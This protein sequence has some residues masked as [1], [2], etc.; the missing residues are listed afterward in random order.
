MAITFTQI[1]LIDE[2]PRKAMLEAS[3]I[4]AAQCL[5]LL[6]ERYNFS[7]EKILPENNRLSD[8]LVMFINGVSIDK[9]R[10]LNTVIV[11]NDRV[12]LM[13]VVLGG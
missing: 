5:T 7:L 12:L 3:S 4:T 11:D 6:A 13:G 8:E 9:A 2:M 1:G 10:G